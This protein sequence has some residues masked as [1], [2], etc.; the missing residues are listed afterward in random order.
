MTMELSQKK[1]RLSMSDGR[2]NPRSRHLR[3]H[4]DGLMAIGR[5]AII[6]DFDEVTPQVN[7]TARDAAVTHDPVFDDCAHHR[8]QG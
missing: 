6:L 1:W 3:R 5:E 7:P 8:G 2:S 4:C